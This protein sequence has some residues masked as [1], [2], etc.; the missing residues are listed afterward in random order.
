VIGIRNLSTRSRITLLVVLAAVPAL[1]MSVYDAADQRTTSERDAREELARTVRLAAREQEQVIEGVRLMLATSAQFLPALQH[2][3]SRCNAFFADLLSHNP[4]RY[5][6][7]GLFDQED[8]LRCDSQPWKGTVSGSGRSYVQMAKRT[9]QFAIGEYQVGNVTKLA[10]INFG[11]PVTNPDGKINAVAF[12]ALDVATFNRMAAATPLPSESVLTVIDRNGTIIARHPYEGARIGQPLRPPSL[13]QTVV[14]GSSGLFQAKDNAGVE[15]LFAYDS[16]GRNSD[17]SV[18]IYVT[19]SRPLSAVF[20]EANTELVRDIVGLIV[21][22]ILLIVGTWYGAEVF[23]LRSLKKLLDTAKRVRAG[24]LEARTDFESGGDE[25]NRLGLE[26]DGMAEALQQRDVELKQALQDLEERSITDALTGLYN[27]RYLQDVLPRALLMAKRRTTTLAFIMIDIDHFKRV[28]DAFGH[29][30]GDVVL[31]EV[32]MLLQSSIR[33]TD[34]AFRYGGEEFAIV[35][36]DASFEGARKKA[37][38]IREAVKRCNLI[39]RGRPLGRIT[40]SFGVAMFPDNGSDAGDLM[41]AADKALYEAKGAG[42]DR[43][44][45]GEKIATTPK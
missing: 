38:D 2:D 23:V 22:T 40:A 3:Q 6:A 17:G 12:V 36:P 26:F 45:T 16:V 41:R 5:H 24:D 39:Y 14:S 8:K 30:A 27:R 18:A 35:L 44:V 4:G 37:E 28:N 10:G 7:A 21:A 34:T 32:G 9:G 33:R 1:A 43:V 29:E 13:R 19:V 31:K 15:R 20:A 25:I 42:R 11:Y